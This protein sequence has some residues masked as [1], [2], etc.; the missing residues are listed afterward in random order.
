MQELDCQ[1]VKKSKV[2]ETNVNKTIP[3]FAFEIKSKLFITS[4]QHPA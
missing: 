1:F 2:Y 4:G 3:F